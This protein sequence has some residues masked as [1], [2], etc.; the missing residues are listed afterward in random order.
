PRHGA[1]ADRGSLLNHMLEKAP[2]PRLPPALKIISAPASRPTLN[3]PLESPAP[4]V[5]TPALNAPPLLNQAGSS[6]VVA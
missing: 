1:A 4:A 6:C 5:T 2:A 3:A